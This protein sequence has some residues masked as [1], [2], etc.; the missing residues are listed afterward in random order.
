MQLGNPRGKV[1]AQAGAAAG[2]VN[3]LYVLLLALDHLGRI[4]FAIVIDGQHQLP[5]FF[6]DADQQ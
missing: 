6:T 4:A 5:G 1:Q 2:R 3:A